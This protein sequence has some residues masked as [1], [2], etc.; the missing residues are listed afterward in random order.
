[1]KE[2]TTAAIEKR[3][4]E[5]NAGS[6]V[7]S[8]PTSSELI[9]QLAPN[10]E[11][12]KDQIEADNSLSAVEKLKALN[13]EDQQLLAAIDKELAAVNQQLAK[14]PNDKKLL[15]KKEV[16][17][18][19]KEETTAA[20][21]QRTNEINAGSD[22]S[23]A[24]TASELIKQ[25]APNYEQRKDQIAADNS[26][27]AVE[28][29]KALNKEDQQLLAAIDKELALVNQQLAKTPNDK[30]LL[31]KK[32]VLSS[33]KEETTAAIEQRTNE[34]NAGSDTATLTSTK[35]V[36][37]KVDPSYT[38]KVAE[39]ESNAGL[40]K[41]DQ[42]EELNKVDQA[43]NEK[44]TT[45]IQK[46]NDQL[47]ENPSDK[48]LQS[49]KESLVK[50]KEEVE[51]NI[52]TREEELKKLESTAISSTEP[53]A[54]IEKIEPGYAKAI[55]KINADPSLTAEEKL[56]QL[57]LKDK[58][59]VESID[60][61]AV[62][63]DKQIAKNPNDKKLTE[64]KAALTELRSVT[65][66]KMEEREQL[67]DSKLTTNLTAENIAEQKV[68]LRDKIDPT[69]TKKLEAAKA[70]P[71]TPV[72]KLTA[73]LKVEQAMLDKIIAEEEQVKKGLSKEPFNSE[74]KTKLIVLNDLK[75][76][77]EASVSSLKKDVETL[78]SGQPL[79]SVTDT[80][81]QEKVN[82]LA[83]AYN[84]VVESIKAADVS[85][86]EK[87]TQLL[88]EE[89][90]LLSAIR[91]N[92]ENVQE[93]LKNNPTDRALQKELKVLEELEK[94]VEAR[95]AE[96]ERT[97]KAA[98]Q[99]PEVTENQKSDKIK[100]LDPEY[101]ETIR[102]IEAN[103]ALTENE[104]L[105]QIQT[106]DQKLLGTTYS[107]LE[108]V[109][110]QLESDPRSTYLKNE[111]NVLNAVAAQLESQIEERQK[112]LNKAETTAVSSAEKEQVIASL[113]PTYQND[114]A[115]IQ[116]LSLPEKEKLT[117]LQAEDRNLLSKAVDKLAEVEEA[118]AQDPTNA[119]RLKEKEILEA[120]INDLRSA[121]EA[122]EAELSGTI[123]ETN[124]TET[125]K[126]E[127]INRV[128]PAYVKTKQEIEEKQELTSTEK[129]QQLVEF[130]NEMLEKV[131]TEKIKTQEKLN[132][133]PSNA[134]L[135]KEVAILEAVQ[136]DVE[137]TVAEQ[138]E[139]AKET[140]LPADIKAVQE[141]M[142]V[143][144]Y[145]DYASKKETIETSKMPEIKK[146]EERIK[147]ETELLTKLQAEEKAL[148][149]LVAKD[150][151]NKE[152]Q[153][154]VEAVKALIA[155]QKVVLEELNA[156]KT[157]MN[158]EVKGAELVTKADETYEKD[159][160]R[161][162]TA[163]TETRN[164]DLAEREAV[165]QDRLNEQITTNEKSLEKKE[166]P[167][168]KAAT[169]I[170]KTELAE[171]K[172]R[173]ESFRTSEEPVVATS[174][175]KESYVA[176]LRED[177]L[178]GKSDAVTSE[179]SSVEQLKEQDQV[180]ESYEKQLE[181][182]IEKKE[183]V[184]ANEPENAT[185]KEELT[186]LKEELKTVQQKRR[187]VKITIGELEKIAVI[188]EPQADELFDDPELKK[189]A[190]E[191]NKLEQQLADPS[192]TSKE[193]QALQKELTQVQKEMAVQET[194]L[195][196]K[197]IDQQEDAST[198]LTTSLKSSATVNEEAQL[199]AR[200]AL[201][202]QEELEDA[203][204]ALKEEAN[205]TK[206]PEEKNYLLNE[207]LNKQEKAND[208]A[209]QA[210]VE[211]EIQRLEEANGIRSL[212]TTAELE[213]KKRRY[214]IQIGE[215]T[216]LI[217]ILDEQIAQAKG[218]DA[219]ALK[220]ERN[221]KVEQRALVQ[222]QLDTVNEQLSIK[223]TVTPTIPAAVAE[224][225]VSYNEERDIAVTEAYRNYEEKATAALAVEKQIANLEAQLTEDKSITKQLVAASIDNPSEENKAKVESNVNRIKQAETELQTLKSELT[226]KQTVAN[227]ALPSNP[228]EAMKMQ[229]LV[230]RGI[231]PIQK[232]A[233]VAALVPLPANGLEIN[234][235]GTNTYSTAKP[236]PVDVKNPT[237]LVYRV[238]VGAFAKPIPQD[239]F[240]EF[241][242]V[243][244]EKLNNSNIVRYMAGFF[245]NSVKV[246]EARDQIKALGYADAFAVA[247]CDGKRI[248][249]A[250]AR[251]L[252][253][254][255]Q[256]VAKGENELM[257]EVATNT[258]EKMGLID[259]VGSAQVSLPKVEEYTYNQVPG[260]VKAEP[261][262][263]HLGLFFTV[264]VGVFNKPVSAKTVYNIQP[265][266]T[267]RLPNG[268][269][270]YSAGMFNSVDEARPKKAEAVERGVKD[271]FITAYYNGDR[272]TLAEAQRLLNEKGPSILE[273]NI[274]QKA[275]G[276]TPA[277]AGTETGTSTETAE[278][279]VEV[280]KERIQIVTKKTFEEFPREILNRYNSHGSFYYDE[281]D[282]R[283]KSSI[284]SSKDE[285]PQVYYFKDDI[286]TLYLAEGMEL[287][288][289]VISV[290]FA[291]PTLPG[292]F[293]DWLL[294]YN[295]RREFIQGE[296][297]IELKLYG[298]SEEKLPEL[299]AKLE[300]FGLIWT[301]EE[302][303]E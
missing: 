243:S 228:E 155:E 65:E 85:E 213:Q 63:L 222:K 215:L 189:L 227:E 40:S 278:P 64:E 280:K 237:G 69:Y 8:A 204:A 45:E 86:A 68:I 88:E 235:A 252:E 83:P 216:K 265:L 303:K 31:A 148:A 91:V 122:R 99:L 270:R 229:N 301:K 143:D 118:L 56:T 154:K 293:I 287:P 203:S 240:K 10:Y 272:I 19:M 50:V 16:L 4:N 197:E 166:D 138:K 92:K 102:A 279:V 126:S 234:T 46:I 160:E 70:K 147:L 80:D 33:M 181:Q 28:K 132:E 298:V 103:S 194:S 123:A 2:E 273:N 133:D 124:V 52:S 219:E 128:D 94:D 60:A 192:F 257:M 36:I 76:D 20:I 108:K 116:R 190:Q 55:D 183:E 295:Y 153:Q 275:Q 101:S 130:G 39:I 131:S 161:L 57:Q 38:E 51:E 248:T 44:V 74:L 302:I 35:E 206:N 17:T 244:G 289:S 96:L 255:G 226:T 284:A 232:M 288:T 207:A 241:N 24:P 93:Q 73:E 43:L 251:I 6:D 114:V 109:D 48:S 236:I 158:A 292:D 53:N 294:R 296:D 205:A 81:K 67:I 290:K 104:K 72:E 212:E 283:V 25:L 168:L 157:R 178:Q 297:A 165:H 175:K 135:K 61:R 186:W 223:E 171:S 163:E 82:A 285:L 145:P 173:E 250:E 182:Q 32:E 113:D 169:E 111:K 125:Q 193:K 34:I 198:E 247:Y 1:M 47:D 258:A 167:E 107:D 202:Q 71:G 106:A 139:L 12:R 187:Q 174:E 253:A 221:E 254:N 79:I 141:R 95:I 179:Y 129:A 263:K 13:K 276:S 49:E 208:I 218:K 75:K 180:L 110:E 37:E 200:T 120:V 264:Q 97:I 149:K 269:I 210:L 195:L 136:Q 238:Q 211:N 134:D 259:S 162:K 7:T 121:I 224:Q 242:P 156:Q 172:T 230:K 199:N 30:Q 220:K 268:Q 58:E 41:K 233:I 185:A 87:A 119:E 231:K 256:C 249:L 274:M 286:D 150:P 164:S 3:T 225:T 54:L 217:T 282:K 281:A 22:V 18:S 78:N 117:K 100:Q 26:L 14:T 27:S 191:E 105:Q 115:V 11:Q 266:M 146:V 209:T 15:A 137:S 159:I 152:L 140:V 300:Q 260:A 98:E 77:T 271:A 214:T 246:V 9:K 5:I 89:N 112:E 239:L 261:V 23:S 170:L 42:L 127:M 176:N 196:T 151:E 90:Q 62:A 299:V 277:T 267:Q 144:V 84:S 21:E 201:A 142:I 188:E 291:A 245:N 59:L 29:L 184:V 262:E 177:L 66:S